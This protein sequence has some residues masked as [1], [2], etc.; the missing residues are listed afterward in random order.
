[1]NGISGRSGIGDD[2]RGRPDQDGDGAGAYERP[3]RD[4]DCEERP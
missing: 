2:A 3:G 4:G 1:M